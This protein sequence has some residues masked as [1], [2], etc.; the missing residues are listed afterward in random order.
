MSPLKQVSECCV[1]IFCEYLACS[2]KGEL[3]PASTLD[4]QCCSFFGDRWPTDQIAAA[5][6][7]CTEKPS[8]STSLDSSD[9]NDRFRL[10]QHV[11]LFFSS[12]E[13]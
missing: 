6:A 11:G 9:E 7:H 3:I 1:K 13:V 10:Q 5:P 8:E 4:P 12:K 2:V